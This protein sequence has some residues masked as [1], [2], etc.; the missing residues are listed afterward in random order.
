MLLLLL[1]LPKGLVPLPVGCAGVA[2][3]ELA[4]VGVAEAE[5]EVADSV[6]A[7]VLGELLMARGDGRKGI[8]DDGDDELTE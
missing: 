2:D 6:G 5:P 4:D 8:W 3:E 7:A 1:L